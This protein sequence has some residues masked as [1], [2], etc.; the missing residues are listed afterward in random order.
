MHSYILTYITAH[1]CTH[2]LARKLT[3]TI[4][5]FLRN[6]CTSSPAQ[7]I[8]ALQLIIENFRLLETAIGALEL[9]NVF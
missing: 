2:A 1:T 4:R 7:H 3:L 5:H 9:F 6:P 8:Q